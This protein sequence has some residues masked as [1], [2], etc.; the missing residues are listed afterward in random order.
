MGINGT[1]YQ[2]QWTFLSSI[3]KMSYKDVETFTEEAS[4]AGQIIAVR[5]SP[6]E[7]ND[8]PWMRLPS[9]KRR[10][11]VD[12]KELPEA[13][14]I[15]FSNRIYIKTGTGPSVLFNQ[16][17]HLA[18]FQN[19][20][21]YKKQKMRFSTHATPRVICC[22]EIV[23]GYLSLPRG[24]LGDMKAL[25]EEYNVRM[26]VED[27]RNV[28]Q[29]VDFVFD[30]T[31]NEEQEEA[32]EGILESD[33]GVF[34]APPGTGKTVL[35]IAAIARRKTNV[36]ILVHR[37]PLMDQW[38]LQIA[39]LPGIDKK[40]IG[41]IGGGKNKSNG[42][43]DIAMV[44]SMDLADGVDDRIADYGFVIVDE[45]H[46]VGAVSFEKV[47]SQV[48]AKYVLGLTATPYR[49]DGHQPIIHMQC[50]PIAHRIKQKDLSA[51]ISASWIVPRSTDFEHAWNDDIK[52]QDVSSRMIEDM[53]R[54]Q[55][56]VQDVVESLDEGRFPLILTERREHLEILA[57]LLEG[58]V[59]VLFQLHGG[60]RQKARREAFERIKES[61]ENCRKVILATGS[62]IGE[63]FDAPRLAQLPQFEK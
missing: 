28:G 8:E 56:I 37:K 23:D 22:A 35:A 55:L 15:V 11:K 42:I 40:E 31:L 6:V 21:F 29:K 5:Q 9:G 45:C 20:E 36:L 4:R 59:E 34:V 50:G 47:L 33:V 2:D 18:A 44:Q 13:L 41:Q 10:F 3:R 27:K 54:N 61:P 52:I 48:K 32:L 58:K 14:D 60:I 39:S 1:P 17:K 24:C 49:R 57:K 43:I 30:G 12:I 63:G 62:Y 38:R 7:E 53:E 25:L 19:P 51:H 16:L 46:H 26:N